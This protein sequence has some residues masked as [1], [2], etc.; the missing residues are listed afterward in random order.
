MLKQAQNP[1]PPIHAGSASVR[2]TKPCWTD[3]Y[4]ME[5][6]ELGSAGV[7]LDKRASTKPGRGTAKE[8]PRLDK[9]YGPR[10]IRNPISPYRFYDVFAEQTYE[11]HSQCQATNRYYES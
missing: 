2:P 1:P 7:F 11:S 8:R 6:Y 5:E 10:C 3:L 9:L 4:I